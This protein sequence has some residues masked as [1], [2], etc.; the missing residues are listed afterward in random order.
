MFRH[1]RHAWIPGSEARLQLSRPATQALAPFVLAV[2]LLFMMVCDAARAN[3]VPAPQPLSPAE[4]ATLRP[5]APIRL[6]VTADAGL[7]LFIALSRSR[8]TGSD[9][10]LAGGTL[11]GPSPIGP[12]GTT[13]EWTAYSS[14]VLSEGTYYWQAYRIDCSHYPNTDCRNEGP[15]RSFRVAEP[16]RG[17]IPSWV[18]V[19]GSTPFYVNNVVGPSSISADRFLLLARRSGER[20][21][22]P[23]QG[24]TSVSP[25]LRDGVNAVGF[26]YTGSGNL[27]VQTDYLE[28]IYGRAR[29]RCRTHW[30]HRV[31]R[32]RGRLHRHGSGR[33]HRHYRRHVHW[34]RHRHCSRG[35]RRVLGQRVV[36]RD[37]AV[38][39]GVIW[40]QGPAYPGPYT[41]DLE[42]T[43]IHEFG[44]FAGN[45]HIYGCENSPMRDVLNSGEWWRDTD[46][47][48]RSS[49]MSVARASKTASASRK[50]APKPGRLVVRRVVNAPVRK[51]V[52]STRGAASYLHR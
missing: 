30:H 27:G 44:H 40:Q 3:H 7:T 29:R 20:W 5:G 24:T 42:S 33:L 50:R 23:Y 38:T 11:G 10:V 6:Q 18:A 36:E 43:L 22:L 39:T 16:V 9:G 51:P 2:L 48:Y 52:D 21:G 8:D 28:T 15:I 45:D 25:G 37:L 19:S 47:W 12:S 1:L 46:D 26:G 17:A 14:Y 13:Y 49:C 41:Y 31:H 4:G 35:N 34:R 32:H